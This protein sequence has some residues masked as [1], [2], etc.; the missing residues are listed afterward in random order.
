MGHR[1]PRRATRARGQAGPR[2]SPGAFPAS[3]RRP[4]HLPATENVG[5]HVLDGLP[6]RWPGIEDDPVA[7]RDAAGV[8]DFGRMREQLAEQVFLRRVD[9]LGQVGVVHARD[10]E[11]VD[12]CLR[13]DV[14]ERHR[15]RSLRHDS[16]RH[17]AGDYSAEQAV[18]HGEDLN[19]W[20]AWTAADIYGCTTANPRCTTPL[21]QRP[22]QLLAFRRPRVRQRGCAE[23]MRS[24]G[25]SAAK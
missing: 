7:V 12:G 10:H 18:R 22:R 6:A 16:R 5:V 17:V 23:G 20:R 13:V 8:R 3:A 9:Q 19:V 14:G 25:G 11:H 2:P 1:S 15:P 24:V 4:R 21:V